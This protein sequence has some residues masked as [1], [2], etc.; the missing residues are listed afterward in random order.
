MKELD[1]PFITNGYF[2][3]EYFCDRENELKIL[4]K[5]LKNDTNYLLISRRKLGKTAL[6][7]CFFDEVKTKKEAICIFVD[8]FATQNLHEFI[9]QFTS[10]VYAVL[11]HHKSHL[12]QFIAFLQSLRIS[13]SYD[14]L[15]GL[16]EFRLQFAPQQPI[17]NT[18]QGLMN[19]L[20]NQNQKIIVAFDEFQ[21][22]AEYPENNT[23]A[24]L[25]TL[26]QR[27]HHVRF[28][29]SGS[30]QR[31]ITELFFNQK[32]PFYNSTVSIA[33]D[34]IEKDKYAKFVDYHFTKNKKQIESEALDFIFEW[35]QTHTYYVQLVCKNCFDLPKKNIKKEDVQ[36]VCKDILFQNESIYQQYRKLLTA[37][38]WKL[39]IAIAKEEAVKKP[40]SF[41][42]LIKYN[43]GSASSVKLAI[44]SLL[45]KRL[46]INTFS[47][48]EEAYLIDDVFFM[49]YLQ[50]K[51]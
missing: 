25:R 45:E 37:N 35:T 49:R 4:K 30:D 39:L 50:Y 41:D 12:K 31:I 26:I 10:S 28:I 19:F 16:P 3:E 9:L 5:M 42:F 38:Q 6:I 51:Y 17:E 36:M 13:I 29:F 24:Q 47:H 40:T 43:L 33:L 48:D 11:K 44:N 21:Q 18:L 20:E 27:M 32:R 23:E 14:S 1:N 34:K 15:S 8:L 2:S 46:I 22:I 7:E